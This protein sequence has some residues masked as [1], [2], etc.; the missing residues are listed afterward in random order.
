MSR[1]SLTVVCLVALLLSCE[2]NIVKDCRDC[3]PGR[4]ET[5]SL[6]IKYGSTDYIPV[7][8]KLTLYEGAVE[9]GIILAEYSID[10]HFL[11]FS[12][13][14]LLYKDYTATL[15]FTLDG[16]KYIT[17]AGACP[18]LGYDDTS[19]EEP[20]WFVYNNTLDLRLRYN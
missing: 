14:A 4:I 18:Q 5:A 9:D 10:D 17:T 16:R 13:D 1:S 8:P 2:E 12:Y 15:E 6:I 3:Y 20:C 7:N 19:C 11:S